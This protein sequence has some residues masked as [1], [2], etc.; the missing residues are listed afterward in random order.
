MTRIL[1]HRRDRNPELC[2]RVRENRIGVVGR[3]VCVEGSSA[4]TSQMRLRRVVCC[5]IEREEVH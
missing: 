5:G 3:D 4:I 1:V 2:V